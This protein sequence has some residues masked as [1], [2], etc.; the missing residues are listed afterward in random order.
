MTAT[1]IGSPRTQQFRNHAAQAISTQSGSDAVEAVTHL[2]V[3]D[4]SALESRLAGAET[5]ASGMAHEARR[6]HAMMEQMHQTAARGLWT[7]ARQAAEV[8][9]L[10]E[11]VEHARRVCNMTEDGTTRA[12]DVLAALSAEPPQPVHPPTILAVVT[13]QRFRGGSFTSSDRETMIIYPFIG[14]ALVDYGPGA[15]SLMEPLFLVEDR[16]LPKAVIEGELSMTLESLL[17]T[18]EHP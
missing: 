3:Q 1:T 15:Q 6:I 2:Y 4:I 8:S 13:D 11:C 17:P 5:E 9:G 14:Y 18:Y 7:G 16:A 10:R 12:V